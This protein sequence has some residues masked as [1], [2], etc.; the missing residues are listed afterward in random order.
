LPAVKLKATYKAQ[1]PENALQRAD[2]SASRKQKVKGLLS[3]WAGLSDL[4]VLRMLK[5]L[6]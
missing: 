3:V 4:H 2:P 1:N 5:L 6:L